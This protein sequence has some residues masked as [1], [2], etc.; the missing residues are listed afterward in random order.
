MHLYNDYTNELNAALD[1]ITGGSPTKA[2]RRTPAAITPEKPVTAKNYPEF[3]THKG[4]L[5][6]VQRQ[7]DPIN[8][9]DRPRRPSIEEIYWAERYADAQ[10]SPEDAIIA[11]ID[12]DFDN[13]EIEAL[14]TQPED[15]DEVP[16]DATLPFSP[17][18]SEDDSVVFG[19]GEAD[20]SIDESE[21]ITPCNEE[22]DEEA[23]RE[24]MRQNAIEA[25]W[26]DMDQLDQEGYGDP[27]EDHLGPQTPGDDFYDDGD[28]PDPYDPEDDDMSN[29]EDDQKDDS[30]DFEA[31]GSLQ[32]RERTVLVRSPGTHWS[33][34]AWGWIRNSTVVHSVLPFHPRPFEN[35]REE[36][37][38]ARDASR[39]FSAYMD[40]GWRRRFHRCVKLRRHHDHGE[41]VQV[42]DHGQQPRRKNIDR[43]I[44]D[45]R[46]IER[47][48][49]RARALDRM[50]ALDYISD[51]NREYDEWL[52]DMMQFEL[53]DWEED[54]EYAQRTQA[55]EDEE[56]LREEENV[57][58]LEYVAWLRTLEA[59]IASRRA[60][61]ENGAE[62]SEAAFQE[63][64][65]MR[66]TTIED[67]MDWLDRA[68]YFSQESDEAIPMFPISIM[69]SRVST[70]CCAECTSCGYEENGVCRSDEASAHEA[71]ESLGHIERA[72]GELMAQR[73]AN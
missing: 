68:A 51:L 52:K 70:A 59:R 39:E 14:N 54:I 7:L 55:E 73:V 15:S 11:R 10:K 28:Y 3:A 60:A 18:Y 66:K 67:D 61:F 69:S 1:E 6:H 5:A 21:V 42:R 49:S 2:P 33:S 9:M 12:G 27:R 71:H 56:P 43:D 41:V 36:R 58:W 37:Q 20:I 47:I 19:V 38:E 40:E 30:R 63:R 4:A 35:D 44:R 65:S 13:E 24:R 16:A 34:Q 22:N 50:L 32:P 53:S 46:W 25:I 29:L 31:S 72:L 62:E 8:D 48:A 23:W 45:E 57:A 26:D 17:M 64:E